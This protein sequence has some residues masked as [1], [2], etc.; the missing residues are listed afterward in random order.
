MTMQAQE[1]VG[2]RVTDTDGQV[3]GTVEQVFT[4]EVDGKPVWARVRAGK[5][6]RFIPL[7]ESRMAADGLSIPFGAQKILGGPEI[8]ADRHMSAAQTD[9]LRRYY[10][11]TV[12][13]Q[14]GQQEQGRQPDE[15]WLV[16]AEERV[17]AGTE[18]LESGRVRI[19]KYVDV[20]PVEQT[21]RV[22]HEEYDVEHVPITAQERVSGEITEGE[23]E[24]ILHAERAV[25]RKEAVPVERV[26]LVTRKVEEDTTI[27]DEIRKE[28]IEVEAADSPA[29]QP[30]EGTDQRHSILSRNRKTA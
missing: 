19:H 1:I 30:A 28:R 22:S 21:V 4:D 8:I 24:V 6:S 7:G 5:Q 9:Q 16:R 12:P 23:R 26:R 11:L 27:R 10:G 2:A 18:M 3:V 29:T 14:A 15:D 13:A 20:E 25:L 17:S